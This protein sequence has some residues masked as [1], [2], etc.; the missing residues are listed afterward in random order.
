MDRAIDIQISRLRRK[1][2]AKTREEVIKTHRGVG[3][4]LDARVV[5]A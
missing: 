5:Q 3:Y 1:L 2:N 4:L